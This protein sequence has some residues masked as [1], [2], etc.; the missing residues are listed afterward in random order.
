MAAESADERVEAGSESTGSWRLMSEGETNSADVVGA[1]VV[2]SRQEENEIMEENPR[3]CW[4]VTRM[5]I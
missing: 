2:C 4:K 5:R 1:V 3:E